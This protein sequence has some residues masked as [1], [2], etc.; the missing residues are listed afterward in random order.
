MPRILAMNLLGNGLSDANQHEAELSV[1]E[2]ELAMKRRLGA[3]EDSILVVQTN[4]ACTYSKIGRNEQASQLERDIYHGRLKLNG[5]EHEKT[6]RAASNYT[7][8]LETLQRYAEAKSLQR[9]II[10]VAR[11]VLGDS[12][13]TTLRTRWMYAMALYDD[14]AAPLDD[15]REAV[16]TLEETERTAQRVFGG[17][18]PLTKAIGRHLPLS[19]AALDARETPSPCQ[20][21]VS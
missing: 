13:D 1:V 11:R 12:N 18:H 6:L 3:S 20:C 14:P 19:R 15:I 7:M 21:S 8:G 10:P 4:L 16:V 2:T 9:K 5:E 17:A